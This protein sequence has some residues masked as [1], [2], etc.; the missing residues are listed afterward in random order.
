MKDELGGKISYLTENNDGDKKA[1]TQIENKT[2]QLEKNKV[3]V[4]NLKERHK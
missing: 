1:K 4:D 2:N 3:H